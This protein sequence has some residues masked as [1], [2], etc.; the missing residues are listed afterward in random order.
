MK[1]KPPNVSDKVYNSIVDKILNN[2]WS[3]GTKITPENQ[4][5]KE[6]GVSRIS[7][8]EALEKLVALNIL[9]KKQG[10]GTFVKELK[11]SFYLNALIPMVFLNKDNIY[12]IQEFR[13][14]IEVDSARLCTQR[15]TEED[16]EKMEKCYKE[17]QL[18]ADK[19]EQFYRADFEFH[20]AIAEGTK[21][22]LVVKVNNIMHELLMFHHERLHR[23]LGPEAGLRHHIK[24]LE[25][26]KSR[27]AELASLFMKRHIQQTI[28]ELKQINL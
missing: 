19:P 11:P 20:M 24:I 13:M 9:E 22:S 16:I 3:S 4:L 1:Q 8:R 27:D 18:Y 5:S 25:S 17:M 10:E 14:M 7:V 26:I 28:E 2:E 23:Y 12:E 21:N 6:L 15:C